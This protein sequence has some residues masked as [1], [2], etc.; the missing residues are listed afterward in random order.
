MEYA[1]P[2]SRSLYF[3]LIVMVFIYAVL[4]F[5][6]GSFGQLALYPVTLLVTFLHEFGHALGGLLTGG[7]VLEL[8]ISPDGSGHTLTR[9]G[10]AAIILMGGYLGSA[11]LGN[12]LFYIGARRRSWAQSTLM[13]VAVLMVLTGILW[14]ESFKS[15]LILFGFAGLL[16]FIAMKTDWEQDVLMF[17]GLAAVLYIIQDFRVGP[18]SDLAHYERVVGIFP[19]QVWM[20][21]WLLLAGAMFLL[22]LRRMIRRG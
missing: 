17:L 16:Y 7:E 18:Q 19:A 4:K 9:G 14:F 11:V 5:L 3:R 8:R 22:S 15:S 20:Y 12:L 1:L 21:I 13:V 6:G 10:N 2:A